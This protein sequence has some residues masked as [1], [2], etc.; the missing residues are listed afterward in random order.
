MP[1][2]KQPHFKYAQ[3][4]D[5]TRQVRLLQLQSQKKDGLLQF[6]LSAVDLSSAPPYTALSYEWGPP[7]DTKTI[8]VNGIAFV[9]QQNLHAFL[10]HVSAHHANQLPINLWIDAVCINQDTGDV[11]N[12]EKNH[13]ILLM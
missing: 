11:H 1:A 4:K 2:P 3:L 8:L 13:Q 6:T 9:V 7:G 10:Q 12:D 5:P